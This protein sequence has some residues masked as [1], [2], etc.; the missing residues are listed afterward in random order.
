MPSY[1]SLNCIATK[2]LLRDDE[3]N[4]FIF[5]FPGIQYSSDNYV[6]VYSE[7]IKFSINTTAIT[8]D[9]DNN[10][11]HE[12]MQKKGHF[13]VGIHRTNNIT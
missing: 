9:M 3:K 11:I 10:G 2:L 13:T 12:V 8:M 7:T 5:S 1:Y 6:C 4:F